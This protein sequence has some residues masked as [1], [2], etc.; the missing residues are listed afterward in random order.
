[1]LLDVDRTSGGRGL[2]SPTHDSVAAMHEWP[3]SGGRSLPG[4]RLT[5]QPRSIWR[6][7]TPTDG[8][9]RATPDV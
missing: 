4:T 9:D 2:E 5:L 6:T 1:M 7:N 8:V 3:G